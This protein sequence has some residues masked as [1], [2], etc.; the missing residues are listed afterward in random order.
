MSNYCDTSKLSI[1]QVDKPIA[2]KMIIKQVNN[3][4][5]LMNKRRN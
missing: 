3:I 4:H 2:K 5:S 1:R